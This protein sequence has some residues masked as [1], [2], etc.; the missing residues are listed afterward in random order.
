MRGAPG[1]ACW[2]GTGEEGFGFFSYGRRDSA[3][4]CRWDVGGG[5][6]V[7]LT[8]RREGAGTGRAGLLS[9]EMS[10][11]SAVSSILQGG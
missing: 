4:L 10:M 1:A 5:G 2:P 6:G 7:L 9:S 3:R 8:R 11:S